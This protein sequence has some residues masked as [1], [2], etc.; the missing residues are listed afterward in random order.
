VPL[1][2]R[3]LTTEADGDQEDA[4]IPPFGGFGID[5]HEPVVDIPVVLARITPLQQ[6]L[7]STT[8]VVTVIEVGIDEGGRID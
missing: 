5:S 7:E 8:N 2:M 4:A 6:A 3:R 1:K